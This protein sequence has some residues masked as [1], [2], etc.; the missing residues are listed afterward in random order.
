[1]VLEYRVKVGKC[2]ICHR[3]GPVHHHHP[4]Y[5]KPNETIEMCASCHKK[6]HMYLNGTV[7]T[8]SNPYKNPMDRLARGNG[9]EG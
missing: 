8:G 5:E 4:D 9:T 2:P 7:R 3:K 6:T 1:M